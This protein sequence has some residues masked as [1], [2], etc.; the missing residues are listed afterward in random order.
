MH[1]EL[2]R[3]QGEKQEE[4]EAENENMGVQRF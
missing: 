1:A 3:K 4:Q 2:L